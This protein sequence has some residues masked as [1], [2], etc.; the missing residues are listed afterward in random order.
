MSGDDPTTEATSM[1]YRQT[2]RLTLACSLATVLAIASVA[3]ADDVED[4]IQE[5]T[6]AYRACDYQGAA[7][8]LE[9]AAQLVRQ[10]R[11]G[12]LQA[13][14]PQPLN[15]WTAEDA[16]AEA[17]S[18][19]MFG[20][21]TTAERVYRKGDA[22]V[23]VRILTDSPMLQGMMGFLTNPA[24][25]A[26]AGIK[27]QRIGDQKAMV[28]YDASSK[29]GE[30]TMVVANRFMITVEGDGAEQQDLVSYAGAIDFKGLQGL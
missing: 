4:S 2:A 9:Y 24:M 20:G 7:G 19:M 8:S 10:K 21:M 27:M 12:A 26:A 16:K 1:P 18:A 13:A 22:R 5:A 29:D 23:T 6:K 15:G 25:A 28:K 11:G 3:R 14:L 30:L 17:M